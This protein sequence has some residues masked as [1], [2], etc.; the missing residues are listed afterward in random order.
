M[1]KQ[2]CEILR[3]FQAVQKGKIV[4]VEYSEYQTFLRLL[5]V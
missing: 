2:T 1:Y 3:T 5:N 4:P